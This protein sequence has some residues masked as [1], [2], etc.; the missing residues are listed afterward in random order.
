MTISNEEKNA[1]IINSV[2]FGDG[3]SIIEVSVSV[4][5]KTEKFHVQT[6]DGEYRCSLGCWILTDDSDG[7]IDFDDYPEF[8]F[9]EI[10]S[11]AEKLAGKHTQ[12]EENNN[13]FN[14]DA[15]PYTRR[16]LR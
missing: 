3:E 7:D 14:K 4:G 1:Q 16:F 15:S 9:N 5:D 13:Y 8:N 2:E 11:V 6:V 10:I 12:G